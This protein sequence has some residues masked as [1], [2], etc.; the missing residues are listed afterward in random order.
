MNDNSLDIRRK[1]PN[2]TEV[3]FGIWLKSVQAT[4]TFLS[5]GDIQYFAPLVRDYLASSEAEIWVLCSDSRVVGFMGLSPNKI[6]AIFVAPEYQR[7]GGGRRLV[8]YAQ[9]C[10]G[11][12]TVDVNEQNPAARGFYE[13]CGFVVEGRSALDSTGRPFPLLHMRRF[14]PIAPS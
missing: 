11:A 8:E 12:L 14:A 9:N 1:L 3:L 5:D 2:D 7:R 10:Y 4:H 13:S 6:E